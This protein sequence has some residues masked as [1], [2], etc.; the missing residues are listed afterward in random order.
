MH[1]P[2]GTLKLIRHVLGAEI[3]KDEAGAEWLALPSGDLIPN[4]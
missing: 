2:K 3:Y 4:I 1:Q